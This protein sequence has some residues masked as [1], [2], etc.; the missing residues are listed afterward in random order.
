[1]VGSAFIPP[2]T[3]SGQVFPKIP[4]SA[5]NLAY[6]ELDFAQPFT[7]ITGVITKPTGDP[8]LAG[9]GTKF[10]LD[11]NNGDYIFFTQHGDADSTV[12]QQ[13]LNVIDPLTAEVD[14]GIIPL[15]GDTD[16]VNVPVFRYDNQP[17]AT[18]P[19]TLLIDPA[20]IT[21][22]KT[23]RRFYYAALW[24]WNWNTSA[25]DN[26]ADSY[27]TSIGVSIQD[28][29]WEDEAEW[30]RTTG[31]ILAY[32]GWNATITTV[33]PDPQLINN[34]NQEIVLYYTTGTE[35]FNGLG[36]TVVDSLSLIEQSNVAQDYKTQLGTA[37]FS[38]PV[39]TFCSINFDA[40]EYFGAYI[41]SP[42]QTNPTGLVGPQF[43]IA[44]QNGFDYVQIANL[45]GTYNATSSFTLENQDFAEGQFQVFVK[46]TTYD[47]IEAVVA[48]KLVE[49]GISVNPEN[50]NWYVKEM[51]DRGDLEE[52]EWPFDDEEEAPVEENPETF[53]PTSENPLDYIP[54]NRKQ[55]ESEEDAD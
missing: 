28:I 39:G 50:V 13:V 3:L 1:M 2:L 42:S 14:A 21:A 44:A 12:L 34:A 11:L 9:T 55:E 48:K 17:P 26:L 45:G 30:V 20:A 16:Y 18:L 6:E 29:G 19:T 54:E 5:M 10:D 35:T 27:A 23:G 31:N 43:S 24:A 7:Q 37:P 49:M 33:A 41:A 46:Y 32:G 22:S 25:I 53:D 51:Q 52:I 38:I 15:A 36:T 8:L 40:T 47:G 4:L